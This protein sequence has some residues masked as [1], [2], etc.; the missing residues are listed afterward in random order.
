MSCWLAHPGRWAASF[1][2]A[3]DRCVAVAARV[4][5]SRGVAG[6]VGIRPRAG[7]DQAERDRAPRDCGALA[8]TGSWKTRILPLIATRL[9]AIDVMRSPSVS[10]RAAGFEQLRAMRSPSGHYP[11]S[12][13]GSAPCASRRARPECGTSARCQRSQRGR[14]RRS[15][16]AG[17]R[18]DAAD[19]GWGAGHPQQ[20]CQETLDSI[21]ITP[22]TLCPRERLLCR[23]V[24]RGARRTL[25]RTSRRLRALAFR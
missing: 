11:T 7:D 18:R 4:V 25:G 24:R 12:M 17:R 19:Q 23:S 6:C 14:R 10:G 1:G 21:A 5:R 3:R 2:D 15:R 22:S 20:A 8:P 13:G 9:P 16:A